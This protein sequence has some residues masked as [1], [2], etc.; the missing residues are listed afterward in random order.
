MLRLLHIGFVVITLLAY[1]PPVIDPS[2]TAVVA[3]LGLLTPV[4]WGIMCL[5]GIYWAFRRDSAVWLSLVTL[6]LGWDA[7]GRIYALPDG[8]VTT[9]GTPIQLVTLNGHGFLP[10]RPGGKSFEYMAAF[11][12]PLS[13][14]VICLQEFPTKEGGKKLGQLIQAATGLTHSFFDPQGRLAVFSKYPLKDGK[15]F[16]FENRVNGFMQ[17]DVSAP[18]GTFR[19][20]NLHL[21]TNGISHIASQVANDAQWQEPKTW[22]KV[23]TMF[24]KYG[25]SNRIRTEQSRQIMKRVADSSYPVVVCGDFNDV[26]SSYLYQLFRQELQDAHLAQGWGLGTTYS[27]LLPGL[28]IDYVMPDAS[29][30]VLDFER[31]PCPFS[32][33]KALFTSLAVQSIQ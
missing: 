27:G 15:I 29:F 12:Q 25:N 21:Q 19:L 20:F 5:W 2:N 31:H 18:D 9:Q 28:R 8:S 11:F 16:F 23:R 22:Q 10:S 32:D 30:G 1:L 6:L 26:P 24:A 14:D 17:V 3:P 33:H 7:I 13:P 4:L